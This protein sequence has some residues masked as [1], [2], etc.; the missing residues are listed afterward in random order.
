MITM[1]SLLP[2]QEG[3]HGKGTNK[4][5]MALWVPCT[6]VHEV[7]QVHRRYLVERMRQWTRIKEDKTG[8]PLG[9]ALTVD[10]AGPAG[11]GRPVAGRRRGPDRGAA[12]EPP[13]G[14][15]RLPGSR[16]RIGPGAKQG[17]P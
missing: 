17:A 9:L 6:D 12:S 8:N 7:V 13:P 4:I 14:P 16:V 1:P 15:P 11:L 5:L 10:V 3:A 2:R